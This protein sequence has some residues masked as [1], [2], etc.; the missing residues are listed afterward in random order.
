MKTLTLSIL[1]LIT[2]VPACKQETAPVVVVEPTLNDLVIENCGIVAQAADGYAAQHGSY[3][4]SVGEFQSFLPGGELLV[5]PYTGLASEPVDGVAGGEG[6][7][8]YRP[9]SNWEKIIAYEVTAFGELDQV[10]E[11]LEPD[12]D[13]MVVANC[14]IVVNAVQAYK[15]Q[16]NVYP[17]RVYDFVS[18]LPNGEYLTNPY[19]SYATE[20]VDGTAASQGEAAYQP[21]FDVNDNVVGCNITGYGEYLGI[22]HQHLD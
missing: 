6:Q 19:S 9:V 18:F 1:V 13:S 16:H 22:Y 5:N 14:H 2:L 11:M 4:G 20:P 7:T 3:P 17:E 15:A 12:L 10:Y 8:G 21:V